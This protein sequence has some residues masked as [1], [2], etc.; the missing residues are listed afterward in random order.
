MNQEPMISKEK[1]IQK[2]AEATLYYGH[3]FDRE[4]IFKQ[5]ISKKYRIKEIDKRI[6]AIRTL[7]EA[8]ALIKV[9]NYGINVPIVYEI[10]YS[11]STIIMSHITGDKLKNLLRILDKS[12]IVKYMSKI[13]VFTARL[14]I[15]GHIH[16]DITTSN[17]II[18]KNRQLFFIDFG[19]HEYSDSVED[20][21]VD[22]HLFKRV[23]MSSHGDIYKL[24]FE[25]FLEG[26]ESEYIQ[27]TQAKK[28][29]CQEIFNNFKIIETRGRYVKKEDR[30]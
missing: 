6:R 15:K 7:N 26:Y 29:E 16:G 8:R 18:T 3:W 5:R 1:V 17:I 27:N 20:K 25:S 14:H 13:G 22:L 21:S 23:L 12:L 28:S 2:G 11:N 24:C 9:K 30:Q 19:L 10:D 4:V